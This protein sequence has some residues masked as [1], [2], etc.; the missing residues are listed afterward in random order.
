MMTGFYKLI[1]ILYCIIFTE[2]RKCMFCSC[3]NMSVA[4]TV[5]THICADIIYIFPLFWNIIEVIQTQSYN[6]QTS[7]HPEVLTDV[8]CL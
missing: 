8:F 4:H 6:I 2:K 1:N 7:V 5:Q 3:F